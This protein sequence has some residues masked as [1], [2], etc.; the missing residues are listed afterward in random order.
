MPKIPVRLQTE[1]KFAAHTKHAAETYGGVR[2]Y[3]ALV[4]QDLIHA[5]NGN[6]QTLREFSLSQAKWYQTDSARLPCYRRRSY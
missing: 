6:A 4:L 2:R 1:P 5:S 3:R